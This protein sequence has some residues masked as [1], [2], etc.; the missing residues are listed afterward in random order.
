MR[1]G[2]FLL[3]G[4]AGAAA[5]MYF[6][7]RKPAMLSAFMGKNKILGGMTGTNADKAGKQQ[8]DAAAKAA[9]TP[10]QTDSQLANAK[11]NLGKIQSMIN[12][13]PSLKVQIGEIL[14]QKNKEELKPI[15]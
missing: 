11:S 9:P 13:D 15:Q 14:S 8:V 4:L 10:T 2:A 12:Q 5:V 3:G 6:S 7:G 1:M